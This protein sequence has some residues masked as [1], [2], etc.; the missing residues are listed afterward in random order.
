[1]IVA[2][3]SAYQVDSGTAE[4]GVGFGSTDVLVVPFFVCSGQLRSEDQERS[5]PDQDSTD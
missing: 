5:Q 4:H 1:M 2:L 3:A